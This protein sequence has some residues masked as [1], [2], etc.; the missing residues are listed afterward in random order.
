MIHVSASSA[1]V[2]RNV[3]TAEFDGVYTFATVPPNYPSMRILLDGTTPTAE[4]GGG[5]GGLPL[6]LTSGDV[7]QVKN[8]PAFDLYGSR[9]G[10]EL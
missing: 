6:V 1:D 4:S 7:V 10:D 2:W 8:T 5:F 9:G 3:F